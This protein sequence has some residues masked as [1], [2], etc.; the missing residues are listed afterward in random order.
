MELQDGPGLNNKRSVHHDQLT[1]LANTIERAL[2]R[3]DFSRA[4]SVVDENFAATLFT[5]PPHRGAEILDQIVSNLD[6]PPPFLAAAHAI[7]RASQAELN[8]TRALTE[9]FDEDNH[10]Q[11]FLL[12][13]FRMADFR[14]HGRIAEA[15]EQVDSAETHLAHPSFSPQ[16]RREWML[17][18]AV[19]IG[20]TSVLA[21]DFTRALSSFMR[22]QMIP[23][24]PPFTFLEREAIVKSALI[25]ASFGNATTADGLLKRTGRVQRTSSWV[26][27]HLDAQE[28]FV[29]ILTYSGDVEEALDRLEAISL[30]DIGEM[31]PFYVVALHRILEAA[32]HHDELEL[33]LEMLDTLPF[34]RT[35]GE[36]FTGSV[37]PLKRAM[38]ALRVGRGAEA[39]RFLERA[40]PSLTYT[41]LVKAAT[42]LYLGRT[43]QAMDQA[44][45]L[46]KETRGFRLMEIRRLSVLATAQHISG[47]S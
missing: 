13:L 29:R 36:G 26:E 40:D 39:V 1:R 3:R 42:D 23:A 12:A 19:Q 28:E 6:Q 46:R 9:T 7:M 43:Q 45:E 47:S 24:A 38:A 4:A 18:A 34:P 11:M 37:I 27:T 22:A 33:Q 2:V 30:Q 17:H 20:I 35:D 25:H 15:V 31:W 16:E 32:G 44:H 41:K 21:G 14:M 5:F 8:N 10:S